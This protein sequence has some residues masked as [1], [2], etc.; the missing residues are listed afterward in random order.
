MKKKEHI[1]NTLMDFLLQDI[2]FKLDNKV[3]KRGVLKLVNIKQF[4]IKFNI[5]SEG[6]VKVFELPYPFKITKTDG[7]C[8]LDYTLSALALGSPTIDNTLKNFRLLQKPLKIYNS[9]IEILKL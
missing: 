4:F 1:E 8:I 6:V 5:E 9:S 3:I 2:V 7:K